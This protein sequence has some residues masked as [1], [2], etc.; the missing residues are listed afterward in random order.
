MNPRKTFVPWAVVLY[1]ILW[2]GVDMLFLF[3]SSLFSIIAWVSF[4]ILF[5]LSE[6]IRLKEFVEDSIYRKKFD[7]SSNL[8]LQ[9]EPRF[10]LGLISHLSLVL[11]YLS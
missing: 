11:F 10:G 6:V 3:A 8:N 9:M 7:S 1:S 5:F 4:A 2:N